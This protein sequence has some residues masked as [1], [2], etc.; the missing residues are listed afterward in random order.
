MNESY[1]DSE[2]IHHFQTDSVKFFKGEDGFFYRQ[3]DWGVHMYYPNMRI[4]FRYIRKNDISLSEYISGFK[5][6]ISSLE[7][8][9]LDFKHFESNICAFYQCMIDDGENIHDL[10]SVGAECREVA[11]NYIK[12]VSIDY[13]DHHYY[14]TVK[15]DFPQTGIN[16]IW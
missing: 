4:M 12:R 9:E 13:Q 3:P 15:S 8:N 11:E 6:F 16:E 1:S 7:S 2:F 14:K 10:F 5:A